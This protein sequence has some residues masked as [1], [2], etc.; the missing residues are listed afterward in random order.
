MDNPA[1]RLPRAWRKE[2]K[3]IERYAPP[4]AEALRRCAAALEQEWQAYRDEELTIP[5]AAD[6]SGYSYRQVY[7]WVK[8]GRVPAVGPPG[9]QRI[10]RVDL[11]RK[12]NE[13][14]LWT[15]P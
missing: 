7:R 3:T 6:E 11:P 1:H 14:C 2:A 9:R 10:R 13:G 5:E 12:A 15:P 4:V 8:D